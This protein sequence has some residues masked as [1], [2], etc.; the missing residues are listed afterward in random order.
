MTPWRT[1]P[2]APYGLAMNEAHAPQDPIRA[3]VLLT[4]FM[5]ALLEDQTPLQLKAFAFNL[6]AKIDAA[7]A[8]IAAGTSTTCAV[9]QAIPVAETFLSEL[10]TTLRG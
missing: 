6:S 2:R 8:M 7:R 3:E 1:R 5:D 10:H 4:W 9:A